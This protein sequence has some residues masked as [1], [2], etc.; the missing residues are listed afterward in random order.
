M[1]PFIKLFV[2]IALM[3]SL[4][5]HAALKIF[6][7]VPEWGALANEVGG[8]KV[9]I[10]NATGALQDPHHVDAKPSL[11]ARARSANLVIAT[12]AELEVG[13]L[14]IVIQQAGNPAINLGKPGYFEA[15][16][17]VKMLEVPT[18]LDRAD[19]DVHAQGN[20]H[21]Q[22][23]PRNIKVI[24][25]ALTKRLAELDAANAHYYQTRYESFKSRW[26][27]AIAKWEKQA[28]PLKGVPI[29]VH[30]R[31]F[32]YL[33]NWLGLRE[34]GALEPKPGVEP[35]IPH[36]AEVLSIVQAQH[37]KMVIRP[38]YMSS[39]ASDWLA[40]KAKISAIAIPFTV[41]GSDGAKDLFGLF[42]DSVQ[43]LLSGLK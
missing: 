41:G 35:T 37:A 11:I 28:A 7:T 27:V 25:E 33:N 36:L 16:Q 17:F 23:D 34:I 15:A 24:A 18:R 6:A 22:L 12:G 29:V 5:A 26:E 32:T 9:T 13:W 43:R 3:L 2:V 1:K 20:P 8:D 39:Q 38:T 31:G 30:H 10:Y 14:P 21:I 42:D 4:P 19:G 40:S